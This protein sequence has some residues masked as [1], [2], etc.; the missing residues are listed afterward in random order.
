MRPL[1]LLLA[2]ATFL[3]VSPL[4][5]AVVVT[6]APIGSPAA[7]AGLEP[8][9]LVVGEL[10]SGGLDEW[11]SRWELSRFVE[12][13]SGGRLLLT[14][15]G[16]QER[17]LVLGPGDP[18]LRVAPV[19]PAIRREAW[20]EFARLAKAKDA[21]GQAAAGERLACDPA[22]SP[23]LRATAA[24]DAAW[25]ARGPR[26]ESL[27]LRLLDVTR[28]AAA[29][30]PEV[31]RFAT[32]RVALT[33]FD[34][35][36]FEEALATYRQ[37]FAAHQAAVGASLSGADA[38]N[39][40]G[41]LLSRLGDPDGSIRAFEEALAIATQ[42]APGTLDEA[43][44]LNN[45]AIAI[46]ATGRH[47]EA[48]RLQRRALAIK[49]RV[50]P[51]SRGVMSSL[52]ALGQLAALR[53]DLA[54]ATRWYERAV[55]T[56]E[57]SESAAWDLDK[58]LEG[59]AGVDLDRG[60]LASAEARHARTLALRRERHGERNSFVADSF[61]GLAEVARER[62]DLAEAE[63][64]L[65]E[66][67]SIHRDLAPCSG[68]VASTLADLAEIA[69]RAG[70]TDDARRLLDEALSILAVAAPGSPLASSALSD[71]AREARLAR[72]IPEANAGAVTALLRQQA[73]GF[74]FGTQGSRLELAR[75]ALAAGEPVVAEEWLREAAEV[76]EAIA[77]ASPLAFE[78]RLEL[79]R[80]LDRSGRGADA[81]PEY[82][83]A[84]A[85][86][87][88]LGAR[89]GDSPE[90][91]AAWRASHLDSLREATEL[92]LRL[93]RDEEAFVMAE[94]GRA[95]E[96]AALLAEREIAFDADLPPAL[97]AE[98]RELLAARRRLVEGMKSSD[99]AP[100]GDSAVDLERRWK[101]LQLRIRAASPRVA[102]LS[103][104]A[105]AGVAEARELLGPRDLLAAWQV[106]DA[107]TILFVVDSDGLAVA[108]LPVGR[109]ALS[110]SVDRIVRLVSEP[111]AGPL[112]PT[113]QPLLARLSDQ[114][115]GPLAGRIAA[116]DRLRFLPDGPL[117]RLPFAVL[118]EPG[119]GPFRHLVE[120]HAIALL[121][122]ISALLELRS[123]RAAHQ[124][125][126]LVALGD[127]VLSEEETGEPAWRDRLGPLPAAREEVA[128]LGRIWGDAATTLV[129][130][131]ASECAL[132]GAAPAATRLHFACHALANERHPLGSALLLS[133]GSPGASTDDDGRLEA[134]EIFEQLRV[135]ADLVALSACRTALGENIDGEGFVGLTRA[136]LHAGARSVVASLWNVADESTA[137]LMAG[138]HE[139]LAAGSAKDEALREAQLAL[140]EG[141]GPDSAP[142]SWAPFVLTGDW[143]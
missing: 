133:V 81:A 98:R 37:V 84:V 5:A 140:L 118:A 119:G 46:E 112:P 9:D 123:R 17:I 51:G 93:G 56:A 22:L 115:F 31:A 89:L 114:L 105:P 43:F 136:F 124:A 49:E 129:G 42:V 82:G 7:A 110:R 103:Y 126:R 14:F 23:E 47:A 130:A 62:G 48:E 77:P 142:A 104:P 101:E 131:E 63:R 44:G 86:L 1:P 100:D 67:L 121:P 64:L 85:I 55:T 35:G 26:R 132:R 28:E 99:D 94:R 78:V 4:R 19:I 2:A 128:A 91:R 106:G 6:S 36:R 65:G 135:E 90:A 70:R 52:V 58:A 134:W 96:L 95:R 21:E 113:A 59:L 40:I 50:A 71:R 3:A 29:E 74:P 66:A 54:G 32:M 139:R 122:S 80:L 109:A 108:R 60:D 141:G 38:L 92:D 18:S 143:R 12:R 79:A 11:T 107:Q 53:G 88:S 97:E 8:G 76:L 34:I 102:A 13:N 73:G 127:P 24:L 45:L 15:R 68:A 39:Q 72:R 27:V 20:D 75:I 138:L 16:T 33:L 69:S 111:D 125:P 120:R 116:A 87:E 137:R 25:G 30:R 117:H 10:Q 57:G 61:A 83:R 41:I